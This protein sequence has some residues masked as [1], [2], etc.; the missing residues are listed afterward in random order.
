MVQDFNSGIAGISYNVLNLPDRIQFM[1]G[2]N[3]QYSYDA[4]GNKRRVIHQTVAGN[5]N[6]PM[7]TTNYTPIAGQTLTL[8]TDYCNNIVYENEVLKYILTPEGYVTKNGSTAVYNYYLKDHLGNNRVVMSVNGRNYT[9]IQKTD[10]FPFGLPYPDGTNP[11]R[12]PYKFGGKEYDEMNG[13][14]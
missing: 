8:I 13:L 12:Q 3:T 14:N 6:V 9:A 11:E 4:S 1:Y 7:G 2:H 5:V 10:Y